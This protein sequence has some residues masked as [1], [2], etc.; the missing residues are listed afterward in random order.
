LLII[1]PRGVVRSAY[2]DTGG[3]VVKKAMNWKQMGPV[4]HGRGEALKV[5]L[6]RAS[7]KVWGRERETRRERG[8]KNLKLEILFVSQRE[9]EV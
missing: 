6:G 3:K 7:G 5:H 1:S 8:R 2:S 4:A 9:T